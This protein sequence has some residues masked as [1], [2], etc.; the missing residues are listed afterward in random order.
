MNTLSI[1]ITIIIITAV[2][3]TGYMFYLIFFKYEPKY[4]SKIINF[5]TKHTNGRF[6][7]NY[8]DLEWGAGGRG[9]LTFTPTDVDF[10]KLDLKKIKL[11][12]EE[13]LFNP[14][15]LVSIPR[16]PLSKDFDILFKLPEEVGDIPEALA[17]TPVGL[18]LKWLVVNQQFVEK[19]IDILKDAVN[20]R[21]ELLKE[22]GDA[23]MTAEFVSRQKAYVKDLAEMMLDTKQQSKKTDTLNLT[24]TGT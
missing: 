16:G 24:K 12:D 19:R 2:G 20:N 8:K 4:K 9:K 13:I 11:K 7:G 5:D 1:L 10:E 18:A 22:V 3:M 21:D 23:E 17:D 15:R 14:G 6:L